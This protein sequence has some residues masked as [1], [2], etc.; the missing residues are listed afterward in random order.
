[1]KPRLSEAPNGIVGASGSLPRARGDLIGL[2]VPT[3]SHA[4]HSA[5]TVPVEL[6]QSATGSAV[7]PRASLVSPK[8]TGA[9]APLGNDTLAAGT[10][11][12][13]NGG[14]NGGRSSHGRHRRTLSD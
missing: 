13:A 5:S 14:A 2:A 12:G 10:L 8:P 7:G 4:T 11:Q 3:S 1:M 6:L 9:R